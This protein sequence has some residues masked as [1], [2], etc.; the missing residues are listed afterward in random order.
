MAAADSGGL[1]YFSGSRHPAGRRKREGRREGESR[2]IRGTDGG[3]SRFL[4]S[5]RISHGFAGILM[6]FRPTPPFFRGLTV[7][8]P[9]PR[10]GEGGW[11][12]GSRL[13][14]MDISRWWWKWKY[15]A[16]F[17]F[18][19]EEKFDRV[20]NSSSGRVWQSMSKQRFFLD[21]A[22]LCFEITRIA[23]F[24]NGRESG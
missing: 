24:S 15:F 18:L 16:L 20:L 2:P 23:F 19:E 17:F 21:F 10:T 1:S 9:F 22:K 6:N 7:P 5:P 13:C 4:G 11:P 8:S 3:N 14:A 12:W